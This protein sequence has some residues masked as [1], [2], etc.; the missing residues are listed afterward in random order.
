MVE[1]E[2]LLLLRVVLCR[3]RVGGVGRRMPVEGRIGEERRSGI[4]QIGQVVLLLLLL[5]E[6][7]LLVGV[8]GLVGLVARRRRRRRRVVVVRVV[9]GVVVAAAARGS[10]FVVEL[11]LLG[12]ARRAR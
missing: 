1:L 7:E 12:A 2:L 3:W 5:Q 4:G 6:R 10:V 9:A 11:S 8:V